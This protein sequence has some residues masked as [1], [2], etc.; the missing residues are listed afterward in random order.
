M[1]SEPWA[2]V[3]K[4]IIEDNNLT[5]G[6]FRTLVSLM[7][8]RVFYGSQSTLA[9]KLGKS[10]SSII[11]HFTSLEKKR[12]IE[13][14]R[15]PG[16]TSSVKVVNTSLIKC[17]DVESAQQGGRADSTVVDKNSNSLEKSLA[18]GRF[19]AE[20]FSDELGRN[21]ENGNLMEWGRCFHE[22]INL[23]F[24]IGELMDVISYI[25]P[26]SFWK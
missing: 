20:M 3:P 8:F 18:E 21:P 11:S 12:R 15:N 26:N 17:L 4:S 16:R 10:R 14:K 7:S 6:E 1:S 2:K 9:D 24:K 23:G 19:L 25:K 22:L 5:D 13:I